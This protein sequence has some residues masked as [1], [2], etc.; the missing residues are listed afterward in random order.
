MDYSYT[1]LIIMKKHTLL[2]S[3]YSSNLIIYNVSPSLVHFSSL[4]P[5]AVNGLAIAR[6]VFKERDSRGEQN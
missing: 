1:M 3:I 4:F 6:E 5:A 2:F